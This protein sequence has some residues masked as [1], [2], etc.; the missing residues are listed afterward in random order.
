MNKLLVTL[1]AGAAV[2]SASAKPKDP[3]LMTVDGQPVTLSEFE[4]LYHKN[5][6]QQ[7]E[8]ESVEQYLQRFIDYKLKVA[9]ARHERQDTTAEYRKDF[10]QYRRELSLPFLADP[11]EEKRILEDA[12]SHTLEDVNID[13]IML[14]LSR[15]EFADSIRAVAVSGKTDFLELAKQYSVDQSVAKNGGSYGWISA[16]VYPFEFEDGAYNTAVGTISE[17]IE[18]PYG[19]HL[20]RVNARRPNAGEVHAAHIL[21]QVAETADDSAAS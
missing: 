14:P 20:L 6:D 18:T 1:L 12:Y 11:E 15:P 19:L 7:L 13:H 4:Y 8:Q 10:R 17:V 21:V 2:V 9:Q 5:A 16:G 3:V